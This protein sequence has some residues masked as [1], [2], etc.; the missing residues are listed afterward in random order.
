MP[1]PTPDSGSPQTTEPQTTEPQTA[2]S[3]HGPGWAGRLSGLALGHFTVDG[4]GSFL[5]PIV[6]LVLAPRLGLD[7]AGAALLLSLHVG[8]LSL[9]QP[10]FGYLSDRLGGRWLV[11]LSPAIAGAAAGYF[12]RAQSLPV[13]LT[14][15]VLNA[16]AIAA[17]HPEAVA[18]AGR[19]E[20]RGSSLATAVFMAAGPIGATLGPL[21]VT[22]L[23]SREINGGLWPLAWGVGVS[24]FLLI[25]FGR[26]RRH[27]RPRLSSEH[28][29]RDALQGHWMSLSGLVTI[30]AVRYFVVTSLS[31]L[32]PLLAAEQIAAAPGSGSAIG[33][34]GLW[35]SLLTGSGALGGILGSALL[36]GGSKRRANYVSFAVA[37]AILLL[38]PHLEGLAMLPALTGL[39]LAL[40]WTTPMVMTM[41]QRIVPQAAALASSMM[42]GLSWSIGGPIAPIASG[43]L[44]SST[45]TTTALTVLAILALL[46]AVLATRLPPRVDARH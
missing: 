13:L 11:L 40:S 43:A 5:A 7:D 2:T 25:T 22:A 12:L 44:R 38:L 17:F 46:P 15:I 39:G 41:G 20:K 6:A 16:A 8:V 3:S 23:A 32:L 34:G 26:G 9:G 33:R 42:L 37:A 14:V 19:L 31:F 27:A 1:P 4:C 29:L 24:T 30:S 36:R 10:F 35:L 28:R 45:S 21:I 18:L